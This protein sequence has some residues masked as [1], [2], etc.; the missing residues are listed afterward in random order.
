MAAVAKGGE[1]EA[2]AALRTAASTGLAQ[3]DVTRAK[4]KPIKN[5][6]I[7]NRLIHLGAPIAPNVSRCQGNRRPQPLSCKAMA[8]TITPAAINK[9]PR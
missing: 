6:P 5:A 3:G 2:A 4:V 8:M 7:G 9:P 1:P